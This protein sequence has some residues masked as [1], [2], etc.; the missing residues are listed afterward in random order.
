[1]NKENYVIFHPYISQEG[2]YG[3][4]QKLYG[5][6]DIAFPTGKDETFLFELEIPTGKIEV[7]IKINNDKI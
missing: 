6:K 3:D 2:R 1:M 5:G 7:T 4:Y